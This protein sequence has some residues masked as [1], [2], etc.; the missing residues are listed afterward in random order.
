[1]GMN[2]SLRV[3]AYWR[4][5]CLLLISNA[6]RLFKGGLN[7]RWHLIDTLGVIHQLCNVKV[8]VFETPS[9][10]RNAPY[11][12]SPYKLNNSVT[13]QGT[14]SSPAGAELEKIHGGVRSRAAE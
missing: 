2:S 8:T 13:N 7:R 10:Y 12:S 4:G 11:Y 1:M 5:S 3:G 6:G 14:L 9:P